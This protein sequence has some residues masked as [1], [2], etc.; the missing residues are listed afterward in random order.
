MSVS[1]AERHM[2][3]EGV[4]ELDFEVLAQLD[5]AKRVAA[6]AFVGDTKC[7]IVKG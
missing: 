4:A 1:Y 5:K 3:D 2:L 6:L 7:T